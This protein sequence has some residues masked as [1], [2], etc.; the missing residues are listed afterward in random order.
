MSFNQT[1][2][3]ARPTLVNSALAAVMSDATLCIKDALADALIKS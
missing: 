1:C 3:A 2:A